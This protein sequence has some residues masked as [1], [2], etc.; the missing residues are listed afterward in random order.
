MD[1][2]M[3][4]ILNIA[5]LI[6]I[7]GFPAYFVIKHDRKGLLSGILFIWFVPILRSLILNAIHPGYRSFSY[8][9]WIFA[10]PILGSVFCFTV[11]I[12]KTITLFVVRKIRKKE[13]ELSTG[14]D[15]ASGKTPNTS[16]SMKSMFSWKKL[17]IFTGLFLFTILGP[18]LNAPTADPQPILEDGRL[19]DLP[20]SAVEVKTFSW[21]GIFAGGRYLMFKAPSDEIDQ[22]ISLSPSLK[23][24]DPE[25][26]S[27]DHKYLLQ[28]G[29]PDYNDP[30]Y[31]NHE[32]YFSGTMAPKWYDP[33]IKIKGRLYKVPADNEH[34]NWGEVII[35]EE[36]NTVYIR[37][38]WS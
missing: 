22:F 21:H 34:H 14:S 20:E 35:N 28:L 5:S 38:T 30:T 24:V 16:S 32:Y 15:L 10:G 1:L 36:T 27:A 18:I 11:Y 17:L 13:T 19:A 33:T 31:N 6:L 9:L 7:F 23:R 29:N 12:S 37:I 8:L 25:I 2:R 26:F 3:A 4:Y